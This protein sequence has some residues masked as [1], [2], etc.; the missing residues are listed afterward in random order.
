MN[1]PRHVHVFPCSYSQ[2][3]LWFLERLSPNQAFY[4][5]PA[6]LRVEAAIDQQAL[7]RAINALIRRHEIL[8]TSFREVDGQPLQV[9]ARHAVAPVRL[10]DLTG[11]HSPI[12]WDDAERPAHR[13]ASLP[14]DLRNP[15]LLRVVLISLAT[16]KHVLLVTCHHSIVDGASMEVLFRDLSTMYDAYASGRRPKL[17]RLRLQFADFS[18]WQRAVRDASTIK[19]E[20]DFWRRELAGLPEQLVLPADKPRRPEQRFRG[21]TVSL[22]VSSIVA[23][24]LRALAKA[25]DATLFMVLTAALQLLLHRFSGAADVA[26]GSP[27]TG[28]HHDQLEGVIG[29]FVN[30]VVIRTRFDDDPSVN[31]LLARVRR[32]VLDAFAHQDVPFEQVVADLAPRRTLSYQPL[33]QVLFGLE[34]IDARDA[35]VSQTTRLPVAT[36]TSK[37]DLTLSLTDDGHEV[38]GYLEYDTDLFEH[39][40]VERMRDCFLTLLSGLAADGE[41]RVSSVPLLGPAQRALLVH[42]WNCTSR[43]FPRDVPVHRL[44]QVQTEASGDSVAVEDGC[45]TLT[46][47]ELGDRALSIARR[48]TAAGVLPGDHVGVCLE[49]SADM[50]AAWLGVLHAGAAYVPLD[51]LY[52]PAR[53]AMLIDDSGARLVISNAIARQALPPSAFTID[54]EESGQAP[55]AP[56]TYAPELAGGEAAAYVVYTSG[57][58][59]TPKGT[60]ILHRAVARLV[61]NTN[62]IT[63]APGDRIAQ[64]SSASFDAATFEVWGALIN[65]ASLVIV[66]RDVMLDPP[67]FAAFLRTEGITVLFITTALFNQIVAERPDAFASLRVLLVGGEM[68][69]PA[70]FREVLAHGRPGTLLHVYGPTETTTFATYF[71]VEEV[72][73]DAVAMP[74]GRPIANTRAYVVDRHL[75][76]VPIGVAGELVIAGDGVAREYLNRPEL[77]AERFIADRWH[78]E[79]GSAYRTGDMVRWRSDG[80]LEILGRFDDQLKIRGFRVEPA[81]VAAVLSAHSAVSHA[82]VVPR[83]DG[84]EKRLVTYV[85]PSTNVSATELRA[86]LRE[87]LPDYMVPAAIVLLDRLPLTANGKVDRAALPPPDIRPITE[88]VAPP[89]TAAEATLAS[90]W[91]DVLRLESVGIHDNFFELGGDSIRA[92]QMVSRAARGGVRL[93]PR[94]LFQHQTIAALSGVLRPADAVN[95]EQGVVLGEVQL[96]PIQHWFFARLPADPQHFNQAVM[97]KLAPTTD[98]EGVDAVAHAL[99]RHHDALRLRFRCVD[100]SWRQWIAPP[101]DDPLVVRYD[102]SAAASNPDDEIVHRATAIQRSLDLEKGPIVR[103]GL[104]V[105]GDHFRLLIAVHHLAIDMVSWQI[106]LEDLHVA[107]EQHTRGVRIQLPPKTA[108]FKAWAE[109]IAAAA[110]GQPHELPWPVEEWRRSCALP[111]DSPCPPGGNTVA[112]SRTWTLSLDA[113][114]TS[115]IASASSSRNA[116]VLHVLI[117][118]LLRALHKWCGRDA[119]ALDIEGHGRDALDEDIDVSRTVGWFTTITPLRFTLPAE[120][121]D[122]AGA[123]RQVQQCLALVGRGNASHGARR[124]LAVDPAFRERAAA[125]SDAPIAFNYMGW[126]DGPSSESDAKTR[127]ILTG[128]TRSGNG[129]RRHIIEIDGGIMD[130]RLTL[131]WTYSAAIHRGETIERLANSMAAALGAFANPAPA[132]VGHPEETPLSA[133]LTPD[134]QEGSGARRATLAIDRGDT[135][136]LSPLQ[137]GILFHALYRPHGGHY[138]VLMA[139]PLAGDLDTDCFRAAWNLVVERQPILRTAFRSIGLEKPLQVVAGTVALTWDIQ[140]WRALPSEQVEPQLEAYLGRERRTGFDTARAPLMRFALLR[141]SN[142][143]WR[144]VWVCHHLLLDGWSRPLVWR[145]AADAYTSLRAG[146]VPILPQRRPYADYIAWLESRD[147]EVAMRFWRSTLSDFDEPT[148]FLAALPVAPAS[149][150]DESF[151]GVTRVLSPALTAQLHATLRRHQLTLSTLVHGAWALLL[152]R[153]TRRDDVV[154]GSTVAGRPADLA[155]VEEMIGPF[156]NTIPARVRIEAGTEAAA[157]FRTIQDQLLAAREF[158]YVSLVHTRACSGLAPGTALFDTLV[159]VENYPGMISGES[160]SPGSVSMEWTNYPLTLSA[161]PGASL[162]LEITH[163]TRIGTEVV[164][165]ILQQLTCLLEAFAGDPQCLVRDLPLLSE[166]ERQRLLVEYNHTEVPF[167]SASLFDLVREQAGRAP[168]VDAVLCGSRR[169][170]YSQLI[171]RVHALVGVLRGAG[172]GRGDRV[173]LLLDRCLELPVAMLAV[174]E[175]GAAYVPLDTTY[176]RERLS[177]LIADAGLGIVLTRDGLAAML[178]NLPVQC[179]PLDS[180]VP[181]LDGGSAGDA[182]GPTVLEHPACVIY[183]SG[184]TGI[185]KGVVVSQRSLVNHVWAV[186]ERYGLQASDRVLQFASPAFDVAGEELFPALSAGATVVMW[187]EAVAPSVAEMISFVAA[188]GLTVVNLP[189][190]FWHEWVDEIDRNHR[191]VPGCLRHVVV[192]TDRA[193]PAKLARWLA[194][195]PHVRWS[196]AYGCTEATVT[197]TTYEPAVHPTDAATRGTVPIGRPLANTRAYVVD[198]DLNPVP[199]GAPGELVLAGEGIALGYLNRPEQTAERFIDERWRSGG[200]R[201]YRTGDLARWRSDGVLELLGRLDDQVKIRGYRIEP[202]EIEAALSLDPAVRQVTVVAQLYQDD[203]RLVA[204]LVCDQSRSVDDLRAFLRDRLPSYLVP[205]AFVR[206]D[207]MP[208]TANGKIDRAALPL[209]V[210]GSATGK[211][212][213]LRTASE[214]AIADIWAEVLGVTAPG[215][216]DNFFYL[217]GHSLTA[218]RIISRIRE[219]FGIDLP[220]R[221]VFDCPTLGELADCIDRHSG[222]ASPAAAIGVRLD[223]GP[224]QLSFAQERLWFLEQLSPGTAL[225]NMPCSMHIR[226]TL[227]LAAL[228]T[229]LRHVIARHEAL[230]TTFSMVDG[231]PVQVVAPSVEIPLGIVDVTTVDQPR[232]ASEAMRL[233]ARETRRPFDLQRGPLIRALIL[234]LGE[235]EHVL[236]TTMHHIVSDGWSVGVF[237]KEL[238]TCY[239]AFSRGRVASLPD[240]PIQYADYAVWQRRWLQGEVLR[241]QLTYWRGQLSAGLSALELPGYRPRPSQRRFRGAY[242]TATLPRGLTKA[243]HGLAERDGATLFMMMLAAWQLVLSRWSG[244][245]DICIG[246]PVAG[247]HRV[248]TEPLIGFFLNNLVVRT[249]LHGDPTFRSLLARVR[250]VALA[251]FAHQDVPFEMLLADLAPPRDPSRTPLF[252][253]FL[254]VLVFDEERMQLPTAVAESFSPAGDRARDESGPASQ[255]ADSS[256]PDVWSQFDLTLYASEREGRLRFVLVYDTDLF[257]RARMDEMLDQ[258]GCVLTEAVKDPDRVI[259]EFSLVAETSRR[260][261]PDPGARLD[262]AWH[263]SVAQLFAARAQQTPDGLAVV[264]GAD[265]VTYRELDERTTQLAHAL[266]ESGLGRG[267]VVGVYAARNASLPWALLGIMKAGGVFTIL[268]PRYPSARLMAQ[269]ELAR[270]RAL[271]CLETAGPMDPALQS[272]ASTAGLLRI[273]LP[274][275]AAARAR[276]TFEQFPVVGAV[277]VCGPDDRACIGFTSGSTGSPKAIAGRHGP[278]THFVPWLAKTFQLT[279]D[280]RF[281]VLSGLAHDPLQREI[282]TPLCLGATIVIPPAEDYDDATRL[283]RWLS[284]SRITVAH[285]TPALGQLLGQGASAIASVKFSGLRLAFFVGDVLRAQDVSRLSEL[286]PN[287]TCVNYYGT[288]ETQRA[289]GYSIVPRFSS[290]FPGARSTSGAETA[291]PLGRGVEDVQLLVLT[292]AGRL[293]GVG[294]LG[295]IFVRSPHL[296]EGYLGD[297]A[298]TAERF[299]SNPAGGLACDRLYRTGDLGRYWPDGQVAFAGRRDSQVKIR[300]F[301]VELGEIEAVISRHGNVR[302]VKVIARQDPGA[303]RQLVMYVVPEAERALRQADLRRMMTEQLPAY[304]IPAHIMILPNLPLTPNGK[305]DVAALPAPAATAKTASAPR[306]PIE[307]DVTAIW[308]SL[309]GVVAAGVDTGFFESGGHSLLSAVLLARVRERFGVG[310]TLAQFFIRPTIAGLAALIAGAGAADALP[311][312][313]R[314]RRAAYKG[315]L[316]ADGQLVELPVVIRQQLLA[317]MECHRNE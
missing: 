239:E 141:I 50:V 270:P 159:V 63:I 88:P 216:D 219:V 40:T 297:A 130:G 93:T 245:E 258:I 231:R 171:E 262:D 266:R 9:V 113:A 293:C 16:R 112:T 145:E 28:R 17:P 248:E 132:T 273:E 116:Q 152:A 200:G 137:E 299:L 136:S 23:N 126:F 274:S 108:S 119:F 246:T 290:A 69:D 265:V 182:Y 80:A 264:D 207:R 147:Q 204:Y 154:F 110:A 162:A 251:A 309:P 81:E 268:D 38:S 174:V 10:V 203:P 85:V 295:E 11:Q 260:L 311:P 278:L 98:V 48:L 304:M 140:D 127:A 193:S 167:R 184:T 134:E 56:T 156:I 27:V 259:S 175:A 62:Y 155:G 104:F 306:S 29:F 240:L 285:L 26:V 185:P 168:D 161:L 234:R 83:V 19:S 1:P 269:M 44:V 284:A 55:V 243:V 91:A 77:S 173:G 226:G 242:A 2:Q 166:C 211:H 261:L 45:L 254:N 51:P 39:A 217:G 32:A 92:I 89:R 144:F 58:T 43:P 177:L 281:S 225:Y 215:V 282:F 72:P 236:V 280:D 118:A 97:I 31:E 160:A 68:A 178:E 79:G 201:G 70:R 267:D 307:A 315:R 208:M 3:R 283:A 129:V 117:A 206:L 224:C 143:E 170:R 238:Q 188:E 232:R 218:T 205:A 199:I 252:Q 76:L 263:G 30:T 102:V 125:L 314:V 135:Y 7:Q 164:D 181:A 169:L 312:L 22:A 124:Y 244:Q 310:V 191:E 279:E 49:R 5:V 53:L 163:T 105:C 317:P 187:P 35:G 67:A 292:D 179:V 78:A 146:E 291:I 133:T 24:D 14:F 220:L 54:I 47:A 107:L 139:M 15:P 6:A 316:D 198:A 142:D 42:E 302:D 59:G 247:R 57:S 189:T 197:S 151:N 148:P 8:R 82:I 150:E 41:P 86:Y 84:S 308:G 115:A 4:N 195:A 158:E 180:L 18:V 103:M 36:G 227:D 257:D 275:F 111:V 212:V 289:V 300:G 221:A 128:P 74:I 37:G 209:P 233:A 229:S 120:R 13:E 52:P 73:D 249:S 276:G 194:S 303:E 100:G 60:V 165:G 131:H 214:Q 64:A 230:R 235:T 272:W 87:R 99:V 296:A 90:V 95:A 61:V 256:E 109:R 313:R 271:V 153:Y 12:S 192:G 213:A 122:M 301:R 96:T 176:P 305:L 101:D 196:N 106:L 75:E 210:F 138:V 250:E 228:E 66:P 65:G 241:E 123:L 298:L 46:Y 34:T 94:Q 114:L 186:I 172:V 294:E 237:L 183:T 222:V 255:A 71:P 20:M 21:A 288:T 253:V 287:L 286:A 25:A 190:P 277:A 202:A 157:W 121:S 223:G 149:Q 33:C